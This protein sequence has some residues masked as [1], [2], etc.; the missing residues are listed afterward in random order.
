MTEIPSGTDIDLGNMCSRIAYDHAVRTFA[1]RAGKPGVVWSG[2]DGSFSN[3]LRFGDTRIGISSDG[4]GTKVEVAERVGSYRTLGFDLMAMVVDDLVSNGI[5]PTTLSNILDVDHLDPQV[6]DE[7]MSGL[8]EAAAAAG[9]TVSGG[10]IAELGS[11]VVGWGHKMH[12]NWCATGIGYLPADTEPVDGSRV[13]VGDAVIALKSR[14]FRSNG[15]SRIR[16]IM[17]GVF[18]ASWHTS[19]FDESQTW[20]EVL[21]TPSFIYAP[22]VAALLDEGHAV[23][24]IAHVTGGGIPDNLA[25]PLRAGTFGARLTEPYPPLPVMRK[26]QEL[27]EVPEPEAY[28]LWNMGNGMLLIVGAGHS[29]ATVERIRAAGYDA[30]IAGTVIP[31]PVISLETGGLWPQTLT[32]PG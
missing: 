32:W 7:L 20:G 25:R 1:H 16:S 12:F 4:I 9:V 10:E 18:G 22:C 21:L 17:E 3:I 28:R 23:V 6:V 31:E 24:G 26:L 15:F 2:L 11:R 19:W 27:G 8:C 13:R 30:R 5:R 14:G 29:H